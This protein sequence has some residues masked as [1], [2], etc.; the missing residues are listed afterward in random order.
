VLESV[1]FV[2][3]TLGVF[4]GDFETGYELV[5]IGGMQLLRDPFTVKGTTKLYLNQRF[6]GHVID[7]DSI[8]VLVA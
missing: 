5:R 6:G 8:K 3:K 4:C 7:N 1:G 2:P